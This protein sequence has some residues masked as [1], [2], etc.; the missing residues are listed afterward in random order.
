[1][2]MQIGT[3]AKQV[4]LT[5]DAIRFYE[6]NALLRRPPRTPG[7]FRQYADTDLQTLEFIRRVQNLGFTLKEVRQ[8]LGLRRRRF[9]PCAAVRRRLEGKLSHVRGKLAALH[10]CKKELRRRTARCPLLSESVN[11]KP[12][13]VK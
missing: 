11:R 3:V 13:N 10:A 2:A 7:G 6:R 4:G 5:P 9:Q 12:E 8:L 1:M